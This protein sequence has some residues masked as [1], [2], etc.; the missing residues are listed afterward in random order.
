MTRHPQLS[1][2]IPLSHLGSS[3]TGGGPSA[4]EHSL[5]PSLSCEALLHWG[6][7]E[8]TFGGSIFSSG[9][10]P[11]GWGEPCWVCS[12]P[13]SHPSSLLCLPLLCC[14]LTP[15]ATGSLWL[16]MPIL[17]PQIH[18]WP[19]QGNTKQLVPGGVPKSPHP[20][21]ENFPEYMKTCQGKAGWS[22]LQL[23]SRYD[24]KKQQNWLWVPGPCKQHSVTHSYT[25][26]YG[27]VPSPDTGHWTGIPW[28]ADGL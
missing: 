16:L 19:N 13:G 18:Y 2:N 26:S 1:L 3:Y 11:R 27:P 8:E 23:H 20:W 14:Q 7:A 12:M 6:E 10:N 24:A 25:T 28:R 21:V 17:C 15:D 5:P 9:G 22:P 4:Y